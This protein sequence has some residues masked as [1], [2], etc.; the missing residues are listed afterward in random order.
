MNS[1]YL[2]DSN[3]MLNFYAR[4]VLLAIG[5]TFACCCFLYVHKY[6]KESG[7]ISRFRMRYSYEEAIPLQGVRHMPWK[8][9]ASRSGMMRSV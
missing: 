5:A 7:D 2:F 8:H 1:P 9:T 4:A 6:F 3:G